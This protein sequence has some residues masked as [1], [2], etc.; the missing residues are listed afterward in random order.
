M[1]DDLTFSIGDIHGRLDLLDAC[2]KAIPEHAGGLPY[3]VIFLGDYIDRGPDSKG[4]IERLMS[5]DPN[6][7]S[8]VKGNHEDM[9]VEAYRWRE[10][11]D[12][13]LWLDNGGEET[14]ISYGAQD[15]GGW[16]AP[17]FWPL[18]PTAHIDWM[19]KLP[20]VCLYR[21]RLFVHAGFRPNVPL[22]EQSADE[23]MWIRDLFLKAE[24]GFPD[25]PHIVHGHTPTHYYLHRH[26]PEL[27]PWRTN[28]DTGAVY[29]GVQ[30]VGVFEGEGGPPSEILRVT[31][32][33]W[34]IEK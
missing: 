10:R 19:E 7:H 17:S 8:F 34:E 2:L 11:S 25:W 3:K 13:R 29:S 23:V 12:V 14:A 4:V 1:A 15:P 9:M 28:L 24:K 33:G 26:S 21:E 22:E 30:Y 18:I 32:Q 20:T 5:L 6:Q 16:G 27:L 31:P